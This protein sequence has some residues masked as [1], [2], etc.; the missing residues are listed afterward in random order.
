ME[1]CNFRLQNA[2]VFIELA[3]QSSL[4]FFRS[5]PALDP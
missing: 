3:N 5:F 2:V 4:D 1:G